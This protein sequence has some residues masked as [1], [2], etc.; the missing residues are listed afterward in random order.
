MTRVKICGITNVADALAAAEAGAD[1]LG[2]VFAS[3][4]RRVAP[5]TVREIVRHLPEFVT[6][7]G[8]FFDAPTDE[9]ATVAADS[10]ISI[11]Q[12]HGSESVEHCD[13]LHMRVI[14]RI[15]VEAGD[16]RARVM[17]RI[18]PY[19]RFTI[20]LDP[21]GG[22]GKSF[23]WNLARG[24]SKRLI[25]AGGLTPENVGQAIRVARPYAVDVSSGVESSAGRKD[26]TKMKAFLDSV[27]EEDGDDSNRAG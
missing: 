7:V 2:F 21:G 27:R 4:P 20:L 8:V 14:K 26:A 17:E 9:I 25:V 22:E 6:T 16:S 24:L 23:N 10:G 13:Q 5:E 1:A 18:A 19:A 12:L 15:R 11:A 3:S